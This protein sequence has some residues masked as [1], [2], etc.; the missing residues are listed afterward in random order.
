[1]AIKLFLKIFFLLPVWV[2]RFVTFQKS[3]IKNNQI[4]D[5]QT[6]VFLTLQSL[7]T[8]TLDD[9]GAFN[10][11]KELREALESGRENLPLNAKPRM[12]VQTIDHFIPTEFG[13][14]KI[15]EY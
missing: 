2:L 14:L 9:P 11:T 3:I 4:L 7:Q 13:K 10:S 1:M 5:F 12:F 15:R 8:N 6:Q